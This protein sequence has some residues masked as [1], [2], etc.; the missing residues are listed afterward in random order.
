[1]ILVEPKISGIRLFECNAFITIGILILVVDDFGTQCGKDLN[2][3]HNWDQLLYTVQLL[4]LNK[5]KSCKTYELDI[6]NGI[7]QRIITRLLSV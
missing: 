3:P 5:S 6:V 4:E 2:V 7:T 1:M